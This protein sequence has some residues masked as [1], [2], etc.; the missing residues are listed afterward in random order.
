M[1]ESG[2]SNAGLMV[3]VRCKGTT[4]STMPLRDLVAQLC[5]DSDLDGSAEVALQGSDT[6]AASWIVLGDVMDM[7]AVASIDEDD[8]E[9]IAD[10]QNAVALALIPAELD[11]S[12]DVSDSG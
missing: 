8:T 9:D 11:G 7:D 5:G 12:A 1:A 4:H 10:V 3:A 6:G 2:E